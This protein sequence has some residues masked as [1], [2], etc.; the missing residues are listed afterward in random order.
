MTA[1]ASGERRQV[2]ERAEYGWL[3]PFGPH[4]LDDTTA[5]AER[6]AADYECT[7]PAGGLGPGTHCAACCY[8]SGIEATS[9]EEFQTAQILLAVPRLVAEIKRLRGTDG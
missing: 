1:P 9:M 4:R 6:L 8:G 3:E 7:S 5:V 2:T